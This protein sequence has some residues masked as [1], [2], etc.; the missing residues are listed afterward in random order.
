MAAALAASALGVAAFLLLGMAVVRGHTRSFDTRVVEALRDPLD[1][2]QARGPRWLSGSARDVTGLGSVVLMA[3]VSLS[4]IGFALLRGNLR[5][6]ALVLMAAGGGWAMMSGLKAVYDRPRPPLPH[7][8][9]MQSR[10]FPSGHALLSAAVYL[11][12]AAV[13][14]ARERRVA[15]RAYIVALGFVVTLAVGATRV[16]LGYHYPTDVV[17]GWIAGSV[18][19]FWCGLATRASGEHS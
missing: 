11:S 5:L 8:V 6:A 10:S 17:A 12:L 14:A 3:G 7:V 1:A 2:A 19:A 9:D 4:V 15:L 18:W 13:L 16:Y